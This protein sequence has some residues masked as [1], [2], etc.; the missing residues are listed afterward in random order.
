MHCTT[1]GINLKSYLSKALN[2]KVLVLQKKNV[3][4]TDILLFVACWA[5]VS[6]SHFMYSEVE[7][8]KEG[9]KGI[10]LIQIKLIYEF[11]GGRIS[12]CA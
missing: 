8:M 5:G 12:I 7:S 11:W 1:K 10:Q 9:G 2:V 4:E 3:P 6:F